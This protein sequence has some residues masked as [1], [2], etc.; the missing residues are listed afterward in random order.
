MTRYLTVFG[1]LVLTVI[2]LHSCNDDAQLFIKLKPGTAILSE[3]YETTSDSSTQNL[4]YFFGAKNELKKTERYQYKNGMLSSLTRLHYVYST[5]INGI[6]SADIYRVRISPDG[7]Y[8]STFNHTRYF[9][10]ASG[11][12]DSSVY[13]NGYKI[14]YILSPIEDSKKLYE[15]YYFRNNVKE[16]YNYII[17]ENNIIIKEGIAMPTGD[18]ATYTYS[19]TNYTDFFY[20]IPVI[21]GFNWKNKDLYILQMVDDADVVEVEG[22]TGGFVTKTIYVNGMANEYY[23]RK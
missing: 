23:Y 4:K 6:I 13:P 10:A 18:T 3:V 20:P 8:D 16:G 1:A 14:V 2:V 5:E 22:I 15:Y 12:C 7:S 21:N 19:D 9:D 11:L 17:I